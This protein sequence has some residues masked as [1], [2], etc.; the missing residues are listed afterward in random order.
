MVPPRLAYIARVEVVRTKPILSVPD[1]N[2]VGH[3]EDDALFRDPGTP[4][5]NDVAPST[6]GLAV[7]VENK[8]ERAR[9]VVCHSV[10][11]DCQQRRRVALRR[12]KGERS[13]DQCFEL[14]S[15]CDDSARPAQSERLLVPTRQY[16]ARPRGLR[17]PA[18]WRCVSATPRR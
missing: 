15:R 12:P 5:A 6:P 11:L 2:A 17:S 1:T 8:A 16:S 13:A 3:R 7:N 14:A 4:S 10:R 9:G 18:C